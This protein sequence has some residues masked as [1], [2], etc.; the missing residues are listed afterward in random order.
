[1]AWKS[2]LN[3]LAAAERRRQREEQR[4]NR[5]LLKQ[6]KQQ[7]KLQ[8]VEEASIEVQLFDE[9]IEQLTSIH[10][11]CTPNVDW[12]SLARQPGPTRPVRE[13]TQEDTAK[14][15]LEAYNPSTSDRILGR[16]KKKQEELA[17]EVVFAAE[18]DEANFRRATEEFERDSRDWQQQ[19]QIAEKVI[20]GDT[21]AYFKVLELFGTLEELD[22]FR[23]TV[24][25][26][27]AADGSIL[28]NVNVPG[29]DIVPQETK[30]LLKSGKLS[31]KDMPKS[32][33]YGL[34]QD[35]VC[36]T[37]IRVGCELLAL[38]PVDHVKVTAFT[39]L[40]NTQTGY[41]E[42]APIVSA[43]IVRETLASLNLEMID[44]SDAL[45]NF[46]H[47]MKFIKTKGF[48]PVDKLA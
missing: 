33:Y 20:S 23:I 4:R 37:V 42:P 7:Q 6:Q 35:F 40:L 14:R 38:L 29:Q 19:K 39:T 46:K 34:Y 27:M 2:T 36:S 43:M 21:S 9:Y 17:R 30:S 15:A 32:R 47:N 1:M 12:A 44:P 48:S 5:E 22:E 11:Y 31:V 10:L 18:R 26:E 45:E 24:K 41:L 16:T 25:L 3:S 8:E 28:A 13:A